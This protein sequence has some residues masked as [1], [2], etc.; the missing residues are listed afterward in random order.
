MAD[1]APLAGSD[2]ALQEVRA[3][4]E[5]FIIRDAGNQIDFENC[6]RKLVYR[7][8]VESILNN[9]NFGNP[10]VEV[11]DILLSFSKTFSD[12]LEKQ[13]HDH[14]WEEGGI[15]VNELG[16]IFLEMGVS[17]CWQLI[18]AVNGMTRINSLDVAASS[19]K[20]AAGQQVL[21]EILS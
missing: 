17:I 12:E 11:F 14:A 9:R 2:T 3:A 16:L 15:Y 19:S 10:K 13:H 18:N 8:F 6:V 1:L 21:L 5:S 7:A 4:I 20:D